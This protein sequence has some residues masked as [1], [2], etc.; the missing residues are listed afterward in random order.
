MSCL[1]E[2]NSH[3]KA[4]VDCHTSQYAELTEKWK[5]L[6]CLIKEYDSIKY[7]VFC[8]DNIVLQKKLITTEMHI[9]NSL[10]MKDV[11]KYTALLDKYKTISMDLI[12]KSGD[13]TDSLIIAE[14]SE[15]EQAY[16]ELC[17]YLKSQVDVYSGTLENLI[18]Y[19]RA[20]KILE[21]RS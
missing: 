5:L 4:I 3:F 10:R 20:K 8:L 11:D 2:L 15:K 13:D 19:I 7:P 14:G 1:A 6:D 9:I 12:D 16:I 21:N 18:S 17:N